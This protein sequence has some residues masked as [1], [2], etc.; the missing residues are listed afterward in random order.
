MTFPPRSCLSISSAMRS[1][2]SAM[3][4]SSFD[5]SRSFFTRSSLLGRETPRIGSPLFL[6]R[7]TLIHFPDPFCSPF[8]SF[9]CFL[10]PLIA[11]LLFPGATSRGELGR[12][13]DDISRFPLF[14]L[15]DRSLMERWQGSPPIAHRSFCL[16]MCTR[17]LAN[18]T[19]KNYTLPAPGSDGRT[20]KGNPA[21][22]ASRVSAH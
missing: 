7:G 6:E 19:A 18:P 1:S 14:F 2:L 9:P 16:W 3:P 17:F 12:R 8:T 20:G 21:G 15:N 13:G 10:H 11:F 5:C 4:R 22:W